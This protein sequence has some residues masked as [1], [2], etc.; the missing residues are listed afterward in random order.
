M[1]SLE[2]YRSKRDFKATAEPKGRKGRRTG[3]SFVIQKHDAR[4]LHYDFRL[5]IDGVLDSWVVPKGPSLNPADKCLAVRTEDHPL[6]YA[7]R[8]GNIPEG[9]YGAGT[10]IIWDRGT[11]VADGDPVKGLQED[12][13]KLR[14]N[15]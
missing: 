12:Q 6:E 2:T 14:P 7:K 5:E 10:V 8:E 9:K 3:D 13:L 1:A 15:G 11:C 4:R